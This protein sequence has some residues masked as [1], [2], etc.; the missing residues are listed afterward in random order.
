MQ[1]GTRPTSKACYH[2]SIA[3][4]SETGNGR[5]RQ[6]KTKETAGKVIFPV[7]CFSG[8]TSAGFNSARSREVGLLDHV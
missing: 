3:I 1:E 2:S 8:L 6:T 7:I 5:N 4:R